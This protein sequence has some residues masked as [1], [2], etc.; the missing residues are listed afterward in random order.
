MN[1]LVPL[2]SLLERA[3]SYAQMIVENSPDAVQSTK[4]ALIRNLHDGGV[5]DAVLK[6]NW[7][8][9]SKQVYLGNNIKVCIAF[10]N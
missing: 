5:E 9:E 1:E 3:V 7:S 2:S 8:L 6:H 4:H 10:Q